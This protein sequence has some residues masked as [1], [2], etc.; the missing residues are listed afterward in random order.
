MKS[1]PRRQFSRHSRLVFSAEALE[2]R[3][4]LSTFTVTTINDSGPGSFRQALTDASS[5]TTDDTISFD[6]AGVFSTPQTISLL[7]ALP[8]VPSSGGALT[9]TGPGAS[10]LTIRRDTS[11]SNFRIFEFAGSILNIS[12]LTISGGAA[13]KGGG[14]FV[15]TSAANI[16]L[17]AVTISGNAVSQAGG[18]I[19]LNSG[20]F[21]T[22]RNSIISANTAASDAGGIY[23]FNGG[24]L[25]V[26]NSTIFN[27][28]NFGN[29]FGY[30]G[31]IYFSGAVSTS[32]P[33][34]FTPSR[35]IVRNSIIN[36]NSA[37]SG[38]GICLLNFTGTLEI[39][40]STVVAN[41][42]LTAGGGIFLGSGNGSILLRNNT[43]A[44]N[45]TDNFPSTNPGG[46]GIARTSTTAGSITVQNS[47]ISGNTN[48]K[49]PDILASAATTTNVNFSAIG[50][51]TGFNLS[52][53]SGNNLPFGA[54][55]MLGSLMNNGGNTLSRLPQPGSPLI[56]AGSNAA[57]PT[58]LNTDQRGS[59]FDRIFG[60]A[61]DIGSLEVQPEVSGI[62]SGPD[63]TTVSGT[64]YSFTVTYSDNHAVDVSS[65]IGNNTAIRVSGPGGYN[66]PANF[67][68]I[69]NPTNGTPRTATYTISPPGGSWDLADGGTYT[70]SLQ[71]N[72]VSDVDHIFALAAAIGRFS[73]AFPEN[74]FVTNANDS[75]PGSLRQA[76]MNSIAIAGQTRL[77]SI[78]PVLLLLSKPSLS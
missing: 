47:V 42:A 1:R 41:N 76:F 58:G 61:V 23:F 56:N 55:L 39:Q 77:F 18:G 21:L 49:A 72:Q 74:F 13:D 44:G 70:V 10:R 71:S 14:L 62:A 15:S 32:P 9:V 68:S 66:V 29:G 48:T 40:N 33:A 5:A 35:L 73:A 25:V 6:T 57:V 8:P 3:I 7:T 34:G 20:A 63:V 27:N 43:L 36:T 50:S 54:D 67:V 53:T 37:S 11:A 28:G 2:P 65:V 16:T 51:Q 38:G 52:A 60:P 64:E 19:Y 75:G 59:A 12:G 24:S 26:D 78:P 69:D 31:G 4:T 45:S 30:G 22:V 46:G 17:D